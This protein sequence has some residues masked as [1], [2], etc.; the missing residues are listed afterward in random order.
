MDKANFILDEF[1]TLGESRYAKKI[2]D[3]AKKSKEN[4]IIFTKPKKNKH[5]LELSTRT[6]RESDKG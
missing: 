5:S 2:I 1:D 3:N 6:V 4:K